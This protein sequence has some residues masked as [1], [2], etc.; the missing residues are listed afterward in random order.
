MREIIQQFDIQVISRLRKLE[1]PLAR[2]AIF[3][4]YFWFGFL[5]LLGISPAAPLVRALF[6]KTINFMPFSVFYTSFSVFEIVIGI[7]FLVRG[8][9]RLAIF[10]L[11]LHLI[12]T[13]LPLIFLPHIAWQAFF[14]PTL[15]GQYIIK[16]VLIAASAVVVGA[17]LIPMT[18]MSKTK[19]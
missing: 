1:V 3:I 6:E 12:T 14:V 9:E 5:K 16:N 8:F 2:T 7:F 18:P 17:K 15:E 13:I 4:V 19:Q 10:L 11:G